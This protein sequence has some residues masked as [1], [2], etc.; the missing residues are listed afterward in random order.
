MTLTK[1]KQVA[2]KLDVFLYEEKIEHFATR[3]PNKMSI[4]FKDFIR[5]HCVVIAE[6]QFSIT[7][8]LK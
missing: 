2:Y 7:F 3:F 1:I 8:K 6:D 4:P 5:T